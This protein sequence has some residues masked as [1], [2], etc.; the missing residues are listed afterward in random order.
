MKKFEELDEEGRGKLD[1]DEVLRRAMKAT[2]VPGPHHM[3]ARCTQKEMVSCIS[4]KVNSIERLGSCCPANKCD[5][6]GLFAAAQPMSVHPIRSECSEPIHENEI[7]VVLT[8]W[9]LCR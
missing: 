8:R 1:G 4:T 5:K 2:R 9:V 3:V 7:P 6:C